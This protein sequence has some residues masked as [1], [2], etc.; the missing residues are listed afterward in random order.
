MSTKREPVS[1]D[2]R[3]S[4]RA[5][6]AEQENISDDMLQT[7]WGR[8]ERERETHSDAAA[9]QWTTLFQRIKAI[10]Q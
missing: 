3:R 7:V 9:C 8:P 6:V 2:E 1:L 5:T 10:P 4:Q